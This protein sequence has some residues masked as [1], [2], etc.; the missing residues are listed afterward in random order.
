M[1]ARMKPV[2]LCNGC[3]ERLDDVSSAMR[4]HASDL[5]RALDKTAAAKLTEERLDALRTDLFAPFNRAQAAWNVY[6]DHLI[7]HGVTLP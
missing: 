1:L 5:S 7:E 3:G 6:R 2:R 4:R